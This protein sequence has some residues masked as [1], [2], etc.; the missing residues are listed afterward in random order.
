[1]DSWLE[2]RLRAK[3]I[4]SLSIFWK[5]N[6]TTTEWGSISNLVYVFSIK[7]KAAFYFVFLHIIKFL[8]GGKE[9]CTNRII[10]S[11]EQK[12]FFFKLVLLSFYLF[13]IGKD[14]ICADVNL[15]LI[16]TNNMVLQRNQINRIWGA[17][18]VGE[19]ISVSIARQNHTTRENKDGNW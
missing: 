3:V 17:A 6:S 14:R 8:L 1:M 5:Q 18:E 9:E 15:P 11:N 12:T 13:G 19:K 4:I 2:K 16:F 10:F 7:V